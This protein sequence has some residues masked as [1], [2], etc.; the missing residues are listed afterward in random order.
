MALA[1]PG[2]PLTEVHRVLLNDGRW[3]G[4]W[5]HARADG[6]AWF[7]A[8]WS[9]IEK[10]CPGTNRGQRN[11]NW[12]ESVATSGLFDLAPRVTVPLL[13]RLSVDA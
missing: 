2:N 8:Y 5:S 7:D 4:W 13:R 12:G 11:I 9:Q 3:A 1:E 6:S 10:A